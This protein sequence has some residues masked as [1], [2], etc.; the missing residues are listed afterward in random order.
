M[1]KLKTE[2]DVIIIGAGAAGLM[3]AIECGKRGR[4]VLVI[5]HNDSPGKKILIS[6]GGRCNFT[7][8]NIS[9]SNFISQNPNFCKSALSRFTPNDFIQLLEKHGIEY[10]E[11]K[12]GQLFCTH[13]AKQMLNMLLD[14]CSGYN[15]DF[16]Y[17]CNVNSIE[18]TDRFIIKTDTA[19]FTGGSLV[20]ASGGLSI[21]KI[22]AGP[23]GFE[24]AKRFGINLVPPSPGLVPLLYCK[25]D[26]EIFSVLSGIS[27]EAVV[28]FKKTKF[29]E[30]ILFTHTGL[31]GPAIL[32]ISSYWDGKSPITIDFLPGIDLLN[33]IN[34][35][36]KEKT[37]LSVFLSTYLPARVANTFTTAF[38]NNKPL[39]QLSN[40]EINRIAETLINYSFN[41]AATAGYE[42]AEVTTGGVDTNEL[43]SKTME[44]KKVPGLFFIGEVVDVTGHLGGYNFQWAWSSGFAAGQFA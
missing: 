5:E 15:V 20:I 41:P 29:H 4:T 33:E 28:K 14:E 26:V 36:R 31:S 12:A 37:T 19:E 42:K 18:K 32:Q 34:T 8:L 25:K 44:S 10:Y 1:N 7:N 2:Y 23:F 9:N 22:G 40:K 43:S 16:N 30:N 17:N 39:N 6:G 21:T 11:K 13:S 27:V 35:H 38:F 24:M 3:C